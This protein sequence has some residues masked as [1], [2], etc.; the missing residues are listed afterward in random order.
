MED[1]MGAGGAKGKGEGEDDNRS[2]EEEMVLVRNQYQQPGGRL[3]PGQS[4]QSEVS[5]APERKYEFYVSV[6]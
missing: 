4:R 1:A 3:Y 6:K 2:H 5:P